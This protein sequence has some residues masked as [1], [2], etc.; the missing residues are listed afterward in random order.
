MPDIIGGKT[1]FTNGAL[2]TMVLVVK[3]DSGKDRLIAI[4]LG[5]NDRFGEVKK[6]IE[7]GISAFSWK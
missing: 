1:G 5:S 4:V 3:A 6:L 7:W 2:E